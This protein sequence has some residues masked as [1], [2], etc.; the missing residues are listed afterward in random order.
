[1]EDGGK[2]NIENIGEAVVHCTI[3]VASQSENAVSK[4]ANV[5]KIVFYYY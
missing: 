1:M 5:G 2:S 4:R 3:S